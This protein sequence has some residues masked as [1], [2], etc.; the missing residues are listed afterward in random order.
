MKTLR[1]AWMRT[2]PA[3]LTDAELEELRELGRRILRDE[4]QEWLRR[5]SLGPVEPAPGGEIVA[6]RSGSVG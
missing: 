1:I 2:D 5:R 6:A 4:H 3:E